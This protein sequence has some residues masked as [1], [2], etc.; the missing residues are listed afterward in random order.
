MKLKHVF[1][2]G[3][4]ATALIFTACKKE[5]TD[6]NSEETVNAQDS[7]Y[8]M[9]V[10]Q[11]NRAEIELGN[12]ALTKGTDSS[13]TS[14]AQMMVND[15]TTAQ[16]D[17]KDLADDI[18]LNVNLDDSLSADQIA[19]RNTLAGLSGAEF[20]KAYIAGQIAAH[21][22]TLTVFDA[23]ISGGVN[24]KLKQF[25]TEKRPT[26]EAHLNLADSLSTAAGE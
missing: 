3:T 25:A 2:A 21:Q 20:D 15:H 26:I 6:N 13:V 10:S 9:Q 5:T 4:F 7:S 8:V 12:L 1:L 22:Q 19:L 24:Q 14:F 18:D 17:L 23:E 16:K 11:S